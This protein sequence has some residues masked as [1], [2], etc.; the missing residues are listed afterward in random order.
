MEE[1]KQITTNLTTFSF[2]EYCEEGSVEYAV[3][4][5]LALGTLCFVLTKVT[6]EMSWVDR[7][8]SILPILYQAHYLFHQ[9]HCKGIQIS[10]RQ[11]VIM[12]FTFMWGARLTYN[13]YR[14]GGFKKGGEDYR[15]EY[16]RKNYHWILVEFLNF[17]FTAYYQII[18]ILWFSS[19]IRE[20]YTGELNVYDYGLFALWLLLFAGE[21]VSDQ[22]QW[23]FQTEK[24]R[25][26]KG[27][28]LDKLPSRFKKGFLTDGLFTYSR[29][30]NFF[31]EIS[32]W[33]VQFFLSVNSC[34]W[35]WSGLGAVLL[36]LLFLG[37]TALTEKIST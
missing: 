37:S 15:W 33:Y 32:L 4:F 14:K 34:G 29:H 16:I 12:F 36:N 24:Y 23:N 2:L 22:Q 5:S 10:Q 9:H 8:W 28:S 21:V 26:L 3:A 6:S 7:I 27:S 19:P 13:F 25:L 18:L 20:A 11:W 35:N 17:A 30:P 31:C 1:L